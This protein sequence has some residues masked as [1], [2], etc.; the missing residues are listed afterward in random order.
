MSGPPVLGKAVFVMYLLRSV[1][2]EPDGEALF[3]QETAPFFC[4]KGP[5]GLDT[6][7]YALS[8]GSML[9][10]YFQDNT[11]IIRPEDGRLAS[12]PGESDDR[13]P[14]RI[15]MLGDVP[16]QNIIGHPD[17]MILWVKVLF[18]QIVTI[19]TTKI[20]NGPGRFA[21]NLK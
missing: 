3:C 17:Q 19:A 5:I 7:G 2:T 6:I 14:G 20:A 10:L 12:M 21:E 15:D 13:I 8:R 9:L 11:I 1:Q 4:Q 18:L 16:L